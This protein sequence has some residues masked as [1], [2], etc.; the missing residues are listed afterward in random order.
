METDTWSE[1]FSD[2]SWQNM[3]VAWEAKRS[4]GGSLFPSKRP[5]EQ[6]QDLLDS[7]FPV[8]AWFAVA[9][10]NVCGQASYA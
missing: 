2:R 5:Q 9:L 8:P 1:L 10:V 7:A 4:S 3:E 6:D